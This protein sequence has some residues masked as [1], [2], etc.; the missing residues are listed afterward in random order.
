ML[1][2][3][4]FKKWIY[5]FTVVLMFIGQLPLHTFAE[6]EENG[7]TLVEDET[8]GSVSVSKGRNVSDSTLAKPRSFIKAMMNESAL[9][10]QTLE[11]GLTPE[12][13]VRKIVGTGVE[14]QGV[15][16]RGADMAAGTFNDNDKNL[17]LNEGIVLSTGNG[18][19]VEGSNTEPSFTMNHGIPGDSDLEELVKDRHLF[20]DDTDFPEEGDSITNTNDAAVLE[21][22]FKA[23]NDQISFQYVMASEEYPEYLEYS[24][25]FGFFVNGENIALIPG[26]NE[27]V[28]ISNINHQKNSTYYKSNESGN[29]HT[30]MDGMT[31]VLSAEASV[32]PGQWNHIK[33]AIADFADTAYDSNVLIKANSFNDRPAQ[34]GTLRIGTIRHIYSSE[35]K[36]MK[37][38]TAVVAETANEIVTAEVEILREDGTD[39][40]VSVSWNALDENGDILAEGTVV[41][42]DGEAVKT[43][44]VPFNKEAKEIRF[45]LTAV[46]GGAEINLKE[47]ERLLTVKE[48]E[49]QT[50]LELTAGDKDTLTVHAKLTNDEVEEVTSKA[51]YHSSNN[52]VVTVSPIGEIAAV[53][54]GQAVIAVTYEGLE[55]QIDVHVLKQE[56]VLQEINVSH[57]SLALQTDDKS[58]LQVIAHYSDGQTKDVTNEA[59]YTS[60]NEAVIQVSTQGE[61]FASGEGNAV[62]L[63]EFGGLPA[64]EIPV[65]VVKPRQL[66]EISFAEPKYGFETG[67]A[68]KLEL[69]ASYDEGEPVNVASNAHYEVL[70]GNPTAVEFQNGV[71]TVSVPG[72]YKVKAVYKDKEAVVTLTVKQLTEILFDQAEF[73][74]DVNETA[75]IKV[76][77]YYENGEPIDITSQADYYSTDLAVAMVE[78]GQ[79][80]ALKEG[81]ATIT[82]A[83]EGQEAMVD[84]SVKKPRAL[85]GISFD[86]QEYTVIHKQAVPFKVM[87]SYDNGETEEI[88]LEDIYTVS[89]EEAV[90]IENGNMKGLK[91]VQ[92]KVNVTAL[93]EGKEAE[94]SVT[95][96]P[97]LDRLQ[98]SVQELALIVN[99]TKELNIEA[100]YSDGSQKNVTA[101][102]TYE[103]K[104]AGIVTVSQAG[105]VT[106]LAAGTTKVTAQYEGK[107][108]E[109]SITVNPVQVPETTGFELRTMDADSKAMIGQAKIMIQ[110]SEQ[111]DIES[112]ETNSQGVYTKETEPGLYDIYVYK[113]GYLPVYEQVTV[114]ADKLSKLTIELQKS[115]L[116]KADFNAE[117]MDMEDITAAGIDVD[118]PENRWIYQF[119]AHLAFHGKNIHIKY[120]GDDTGKLYNGKPW[121]LGG[122]YY[123]YPY[124]IPVDYQDPSVKVPMLAYMVVPGEVSWLKEFFK[125][126]LAIENLAP[127]PFKLKD[128]K[129]S[130]TLP[131]G[132][133][134][135]TVREDQTLEVNI[136]DIQGGETFYHEWYIRGDQKGQYDLEAVFTST[137]DPFNEAVNARFVTPKPITVWGDDALEM[138]IKAEQ[139]AKAGM[140]YEVQFGL[141]NVSDAPIYFLN[142]SLKEEG[143]LNYFYSPKT[144]RSYS[145]E[146]IQAGETVW[147]KFLLIPRISGP[148]D[149]SKSFVLHTG[150][151]ADITTVISPLD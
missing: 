38:S 87:A 137:L 24:D 151:N 62:I 117:R 5:V 20:N 48:L 52:D 123:L 57:E 77:A 3:R 74:L 145:I 35:A 9:Q 98:S 134:L 148:L 16:F 23:V 56:P 139:T 15:T 28:T 55:V 132:L 96:V 39:G 102:V 86:Q 4:Q 146:E 120:Y 141:K 121:D 71:V 59:T 127:A 30:Q 70:E 116:I 130:L 131:E 11:D 133:S 103:A 7:S 40:D 2:K 136:G 135:A 107:T 99:E 19:G 95:V 65:E 112:A 97:Y 126:Q 67:Q 37:G 18:K 92:E 149:V 88:T 105:V 22:D 106:A 76:T 140:P 61:I 147:F 144:E 8:T 100:V 75:S 118:D 36:L 17:G 34:P 90:E 27:P 124:L 49:V 47:S 14:V 29:F 45:Q 80:K 60:S 25:V 150:G 51:M 50:E 72:V 6:V 68:I 108:Y 69:V 46:T 53:G 109:L 43:V 85:T 82:A 10:V 42:A 41:F 93:Y 79:L 13:L 101:S 110:K 125:A 81:T 78:N 26:S 73:V 111:E 66:Q 12:E 115:E 128:S 84:V 32:S 21:F 83:Y 104:T 91:P 142:F 114:E 58:K 143:K 138:H 129:V 64:K 33:L 94:V 1:S 63:V 54:T 119:E 122:G 31:T 44:K 89:N 113:P